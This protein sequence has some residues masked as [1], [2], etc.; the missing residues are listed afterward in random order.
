[1]RQ[2]ADAVHTVA[3]RVPFWRLDD[4]GDEIVIR[5]LDGPPLVTF[6]GMYAAEMARWFGLIG[7]RTAGMAVAN[8]IR[9]SAS[10]AE[11]APGRDAALQLLQEMELEPKP[12]RYHRR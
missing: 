1:M 6:H 10:S 5:D 7:H 3:S 9:A 11:Q 12:T 4:S 8:L 2:H